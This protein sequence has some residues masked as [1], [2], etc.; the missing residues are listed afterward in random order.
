MKVYIVKCKEYSLSS[1]K[2][3][4]LS[5]SSTEELAKKSS[6]LLREDFQSQLGGSWAQLQDLDWDTDRWENKFNLQIIFTQ[7]WGVD[8]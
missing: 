2:E 6:A 5:V 3:Y 8:L 4:I 7:E 1:P